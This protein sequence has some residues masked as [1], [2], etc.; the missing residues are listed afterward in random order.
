MV[1]THFLRLNP[2]V[3]PIA[4]FR[5]LPE[6]EIGATAVEYCLLVAFIATVIIF[7]V[8]TLGDQLTP[9]FQ[10]VIELL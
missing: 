9:G 6:S 8:Q 7:A 4:G 1:R 5:R 3:K 10:A 2:F